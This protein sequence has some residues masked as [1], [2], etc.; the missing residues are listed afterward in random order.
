MEL[1]KLRLIA[2]VGKDLSQ[3]PD[4][5]P[6]FLKLLLEGSYVAGQIPRFTARGQPQDQLLLICDDLIQALD[7][8]VLDLVLAL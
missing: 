6:A 3:R 7:L 5:S 2:F 4:F 8:E 1:L